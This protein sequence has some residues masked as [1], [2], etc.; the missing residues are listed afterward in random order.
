MSN[1]TKNV[2]VAQASDLLAAAK[3]RAAATRTAAAGE[4]RELLQSTE[5]DK[6]DAGRLLKILDTLGIGLDDV[7]AITENLREV[8]RCEALLAEAG[9]RRERLTAAHASR[10]EF[11]GWRDAALRELNAEIQRRQSVAETECRLALRALD[12]I[13]TARHRL[14]QATA[15]WELIASGPKPAP[16]PESGSGYLANEVIPALQPGSQ[17]TAAQQR[18][19]LLGA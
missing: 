1:G 19:V 18:A 6:N 5:P 12:A 8:Q 3:A 4:L 15:A 17:R 13:G 7:P 14:A 10:R 9:P 2:L 16:P 11:L